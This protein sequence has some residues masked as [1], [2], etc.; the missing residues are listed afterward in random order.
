MSRTSSALSSTSSTFEV[1]DVLVLI[2]FRALMLLVGQYEGMQP[3][4][5]SD[6]VLARFSVWSKMQMICI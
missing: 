2:A 6:E 3:V 5:L 1:L 4:K